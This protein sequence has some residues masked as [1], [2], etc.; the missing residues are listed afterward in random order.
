MEHDNHNELKDAPILR[1]L[2]GHDPFASPAGFFDR[3]P[4]QVQGAVPR[5]P[6]RLPAWRRPG[7]WAGAVAAVLAVVIVSVRWNDGPTTSPAT[8]AETPITDDL[9]D[10]MWTDGYPLTTMELA[11]VIED[12]H[13]GTA[14][15]PLGPDE[16]LGYLY[17][18]DIPLDL[19]I[20]EL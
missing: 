1:G 5:T 15:L 8:V 16:W 6:Q 3:F 17:H 12:T 2:R 11:G 4:H 7:V 19:L 9:D 10:L 14:D 20:E 13:L 18:A